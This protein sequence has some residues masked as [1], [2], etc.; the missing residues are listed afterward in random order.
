MA[1]MVRK[2]V[3][4]PPDLVERIRVFR[5]ARMID[6]ESEAVRLLLQAGLEAFAREPEP[7]GERDQ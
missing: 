5:F 4:L 3:N 7:P 2:L 6:T 1:P